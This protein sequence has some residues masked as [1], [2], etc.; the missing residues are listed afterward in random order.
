MGLRLVVC[1]PLL[2]PN[3]FL[4]F[5]SSQATPLCRVIHELNTD[6][7]YTET[8]AQKAKEVAGMSTGEA[9]GKASELAGE[10]KGKVHEVAG[11]AKGKAN[12]IKGK[13]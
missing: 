9:K 1:L 10:A 6:S 4:C 12:E 11:E 7:S 5:L 13:M 2:Q 3:F 8:A